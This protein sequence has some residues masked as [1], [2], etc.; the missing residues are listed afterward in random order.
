MHNKIAIALIA[1]IPL[2]GCSQPEWKVD[3]NIHQ[4]LFMD[5]ILTIPDAS[6]LS[7]VFRYEVFQSCQETATHQSKLCI[8]NCPSGVQTQPFIKPNQPQ[9]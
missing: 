8:K 1:C 6:Q 2:A 3:H 5:C 4:R 7:E 9:N